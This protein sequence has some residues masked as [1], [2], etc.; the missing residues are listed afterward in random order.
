MSARS[1]P[2]ASDTRLARVCAAAGAGA[3][4]AAS[5]AGR[6]DAAIAA[7][8]PIRVVLRKF[9]RDLWHSIIYPPLLTQLLPEYI[10]QFKRVTRR[11]TA[12]RN[13]M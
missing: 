3:A 7:A 2:P 10:Q 5:A 11:E 13:V 9:L 8:P 4:G 6:C 1:L 12:L